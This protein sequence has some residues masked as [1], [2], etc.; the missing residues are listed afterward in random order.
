MRSFAEVMGEATSSAYEEIDTCPTFG[1]NFVD[2]FEVEGRAG[3]FL[4]GIEIGS[5]EGVIYEG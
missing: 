4:D 3:V 1:R 5:D 2:H